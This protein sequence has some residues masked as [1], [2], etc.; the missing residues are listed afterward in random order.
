MDERIH[1][2][3][4]VLVDWSACIQAGDNVVVSV[5][6]GAHSRRRRRETRSVGAE[7]VTT[8]AS[9]EMRRSRYVTGPV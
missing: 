5:G 9:E 3:A 6:E 4:E 8:Y 1:E 7:T 2:H